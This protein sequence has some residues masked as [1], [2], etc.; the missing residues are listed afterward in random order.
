MSEANMGF[1]QTSYWRLRALHYTR[2]VGCGPPLCVTSSA[3]AGA[4][5]INKPLW[6]WWGAVCVSHQ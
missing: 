1:E 3:K 2:L 4:G 5:A 6:A